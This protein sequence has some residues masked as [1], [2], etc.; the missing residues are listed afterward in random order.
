MRSKQI[1]FYFL[2]FV[3]LA[4]LWWAA[5][6]LISIFIEK[7]SYVGTSYYGDQYYDYSNFNDRLALRLTAILI[8]LPV[9]IFHWLKTSGDVFQSK[10]DEFTE[11]QLG[12]RRWYSQIVMIFS[13]LMFLFFLTLIL[14]EITKNILYFRGF[15]LFTLRTSVPYLVASSLVWLYHW[16][17]FKDCDQRFSKVAPEVVFKKSGDSFCAFCGAKLI[18][19]ALYCTNCG[20]KIER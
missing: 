1:Y 17:V 16:S 14:Y 6:D 3:S 10:L 19:G 15:S 7:F 20:K 8:A 4:V 9:Y 13:G 2:S 18:P 5:A 11:G 12:Q